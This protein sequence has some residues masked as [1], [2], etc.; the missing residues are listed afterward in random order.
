MNEFVLGQYVPLNSL[1]HSLDSRIKIISFLL[2]ILATT[3]AKGISFI[4]IILIIIMI[5][6]LSRV[7]F[8]LIW[9]SLKFL[10]VLLIITFFLQIC[11]TPG[12]EIFSIFFLKITKEGFLQGGE[13]F[14]RIVLLMLVGSLLT[15]TT[16]PTNLTGGLER[17]GKPLARLGVPV[18]EIAM[19]I[20]IALRFVPL[21]LSEALTISKAQQARGAKFRGVNWKK[22]KD[23]LLSLVVPMFSIAFRRADELS[24]AME[25]RCY[26]GG[27]GK[28]SM[29]EYQ[30]QLKDYGILTMSSILLL[31]TIVLKFV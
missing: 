27:I 15:I 26:N 7:P 23:Y 14:L 31:V 20:T 28:T 3:I 11:F 18:S 1:V 19:M 8:K 21:V 29:K 25:A 22:K 9:K 16:T 10:W 17:L 5:I 24:L 6:F 12:E 2:I 30:C 13:T 4:P